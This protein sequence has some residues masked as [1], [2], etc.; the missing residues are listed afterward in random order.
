VSMAL[1]TAELQQFQAAIA[2]RLGLRFDDGKLTFLAEVLGR[3]MAARGVDA[4]SYLEALQ[5]DLSAE[6]E[7]RALALE[8]TVGETYFFRHAEQ[9]SAL[10]EVALP[11]R[12]AGMAR[13]GTLRLV[14]VGC[15]S[16]EEPYSLAILQQQQRAFDARFRVEILGMDLNPESLQKAR[17]GLY[18]AWSLRETP[19]NVRE[20]WFQ[21][22]GQNFR[23]APAVRDAV[24]F[25]EHN[26]IRPSA[27]LLSPSTCDVIFCRNVL[28][29]FT[30]EHAANIVQRLAR[31]LVPGG[32]LFLGHAENLRGLSHAFH[33][34]HTHN[35]FYY[36]R[37]DV[38]P[39]DYSAAPVTP[40]EAPR[41]VAAA[42][43]PWT[44]HWLQAVQASSDRIRELSEPR[45]TATESEPPAMLT[46]LLGRPDLRQPLELLQSERFSEA[47]ESL[48]Q[49]PAALASDPAALLL[50]AALLTL[51][52]ELSPAE[53]ACRQLLE[54][55]ELNAGAHYLLALC[56]E[57]KEELSIAAEHARTAVYL[58]AGFAMPHLQL[59]LMARRRHDPEVARREIGQAL[60]LLEREDPARLLLFGGGFTRAALLDLCRSELENL[61]GKR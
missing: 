51:Q 49:S 2:R 1:G 52:G 47:L 61:R 55:D 4:T 50:R 26:L 15:A 25:H 33:L 24:Q 35:T 39:V 16:G 5:G 46:A 40:D 23:I 58:D 20:R 28:M 32:F 8:L 19:P 22:E 59:G 42:S 56:F 53:A 54:L 57:R 30:P 11:E 12:T 34:R 6:D 60:W 29:Y 17:R 45:P 44:D 37:K 10:C 27:E 7:V 9:F 48:H 38:L 3:R 43:G 13:S 18:S 31:A 14:S 41:A 21:P 36:Q